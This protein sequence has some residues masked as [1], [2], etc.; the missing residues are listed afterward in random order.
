ML[1][2][3]TLFKFIKTIIKVFVF[4]KII[5]CSCLLKRLEEIKLNGK[6]REGNVGKD[7]FQTF[8]CKSN[9][10]FYIEL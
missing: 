2:N 1:V 10:M 5:L 8:S 7:I 3:T 4:I 6:K 9:I